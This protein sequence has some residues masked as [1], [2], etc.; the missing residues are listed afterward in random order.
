M[1]FWYFFLMLYFKLKLW[2]ILLLWLKPFPESY[3]YV[4]YYYRVSTKKG[5]FTILYSVVGAKRSFFCGYTVYV[6]W[7]LSCKKKKDVSG[8]IEDGVHNEKYFSL[9]Q[10][11]NIKF[12]PLTLFQISYDFC[13]VF[14]HTKDSFRHSV[15]CSFEKMS[16]GPGDV[17]IK[18]IESKHNK[19]QYMK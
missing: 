17:P 4:L 5:S 15:M 14:G 6:P 13:Q 10:S 7:L 18:D 16:K 2:K 9:V 19:N 8:I 12:F 3:I 11:N 1:I